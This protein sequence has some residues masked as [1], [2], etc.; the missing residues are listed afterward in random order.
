MHM[1]SEL[2]ANV[3]RGRDALAAEFAKAAD[4]FRAEREARETA[5][6]ESTGRIGDEAAAKYQ[7][8]LQTA[9][10]SW[11]VSSVRRLNEHGQNAVDGLLRSADQAL[12]D[13]FARVFEGLSEALRERPSSSGSGRAHA[14]GFTPPENPDSP[15]PPPQ[16][17][18]SSTSANA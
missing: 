1:A 14:G 2:D 18:G 8:R 5:W 3:A 11:A 13:S 6:T 7:E 15:M 17:E 10:D 9:S 16:S 12:R 4:G